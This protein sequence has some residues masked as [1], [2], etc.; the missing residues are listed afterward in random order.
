MLEKQK[1]RE[2]KMPK[3]H[4]T[5][6]LPYTAEQMYELVEKVED[7]PQFLPWCGGATVHSRTDSNMEA[8]IV[9]AFK[10]LHQTF[11]TH[12][13]NTRPHLMLMEFKNGPFRYLKGSW[14]FESVG[15]SGVKVMFDLDYEFSSKLF[16]LAIGPVFNVIAQTF[17][18]GFVSRAKVIYGQH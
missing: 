7:Y 4:K 13:Q 8:S 12:N 6:L 15:D 18:D 14:R 3:V 10:G 16:S 17:I 1:N 5:V 2:C 11:R 9:I